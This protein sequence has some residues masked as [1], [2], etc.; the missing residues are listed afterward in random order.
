MKLVALSIMCLINPISS[1]SCGPVVSITVN[2][3]PRPAS[4]AVRILELT[5]DIP[6]KV[7]VTIKNE[8][9]E[10]I[11]AVAPFGRAGPSTYTIVV[12]DGG[13][14]GERR[15]VLQALHLEDGKEAPI[16][17]VKKARFR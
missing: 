2:Q 11:G 13:S 8:A 12:N 9:G 17:C 7:S 1:P 6:A 5:I 16:I 4:E 10:I 14:D 3:P 15:F